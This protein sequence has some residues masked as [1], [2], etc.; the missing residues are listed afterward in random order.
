MNHNLVRKSLPENSKSDQVIRENPASR[1]TETSAEELPVARK[2]TGKQGKNDVPEG[3]GRASKNERASPCATGVF[4]VRVEI[5][6]TVS[7]R[8]GR[9]PKP[10]AGRAAH[11]DS[12]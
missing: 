9:A 10:P 6:R 2:G 4:A 5:C 12:S 1:G 11:R 8:A 3:R 7:F